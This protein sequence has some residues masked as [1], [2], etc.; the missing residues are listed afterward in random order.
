[1]ASGSVEFVPE[2]GS[3][4]PFLL[5]LCLH[6]DQVGRDGHGV[7]RV[8]VPGAEEEEEQEE[9][10]GEKAVKRQLTEEEEEGE[11]DIGAKKHEKRDNEEEEEAVVPESLTEEDKRAMNA[12]TADSIEAQRAQ[13]D[14]AT[15]EEQDT[16]EAPGNDL[17]NNPSPDGQVAGLED[18]EDPA[19]VQQ[20]RDG[21]GVLSA[22]SAFSTGCCESAVFTR[23]LHACL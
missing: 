13:A 5:G 9:D 16:E 14:S 17:E 19:N 22:L 8:K 6:G 3:P 4:L 21:G 15:R 18:E 1:M 10:E 11:E 12:D 2:E 7:H 23:A 20:D